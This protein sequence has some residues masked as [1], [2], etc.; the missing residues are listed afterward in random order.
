MIDFKYQ[1]Y[2][3]D[4][5]DVYINDKDETVTFVFLSTRERIQLHVKDYLIDLLPSMDGINT[6]ENLIEM[7]GKKKK[8]QVIEFVSYLNQKGVLTNM[9]WFEK[10]PFDFEYKSRLE[11]QI[12]FLMDMT[13]SAEKTFQ[14]QNKIKVTNVAIWGMGG[15]GSWLLVELL[16]MGFENIK[17]FDFD[18]VNSSDI[19]RHAFYAKDFQNVLKVNAYKEIGTAINPKANISPFEVSLKTKCELNQHLDDVDLIIN[20]ADEPYIGYTSISLSRYCVAKNKLLFVA[21]GFDAHLASLGEMIIPFKTPCSDCYNSYFKKSLENWK[22]IKH[23]VSN[24]NKGFG[25]LIS[26]SIF[27]ASTATLAILRYFIDSERFL[28]E[29]SGR[30]EFK[31]DNYNID[32][33]VV[34]KNPKCEI[35]SD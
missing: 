6:V 4:G 29:S 2:L 10:L 34:E 31:F 14:V 8:K 3:R 23:P 24:R 21:G 12:Y 13:Q 16:Q 9:D 19:S 11:K 18:I 30:G 17:I 20:T 7:V 33:F 35:C 25:G 5:V 26:L 32:S 15:V 28:S 22:P 1:P 27:S